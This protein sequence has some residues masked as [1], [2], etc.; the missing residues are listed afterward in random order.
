MWLN[1]ASSDGE[2][3]RNLSG[4]IRSR[5]PPR[6][7]NAYITVGR[8]H[9][10]YSV[11]SSTSVHTQIGLSQISQQLN[12]ALCPHTL[13]TALAVSRT[14]STLATATRRSPP[15][16]PLTATLQLAQAL[17]VSFLPVF[18]GSPPSVAVTGDWCYVTRDTSPYQV[19]CDLVVP[20][21]FC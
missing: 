4:Y 12:I 13:D 5:R 21:L 20:K 8:D 2:S 9:E 10:N 3:S 16:P 7:A 19:K 17:S 14:S 1:L 6:P 15:C 11:A 18:K